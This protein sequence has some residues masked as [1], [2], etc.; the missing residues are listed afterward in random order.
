MM[1]IDSIKGNPMSERDITKYGA[2]IVRANVASGTTYWKIIDAYHLSGQQ[3]HGNH[4]VFADVLN[5]DG[6]RR[7]GAHC[8][9]YFAGRTAVLTIDKPA[10]EPGT[11]APMYRGNFYDIEGADLP[12]DKAIHFSSEWPDEE[13][14]NTNGHHSF[15]VIFQ[16]TI[17]G[18][19]TTGSIR[20]TVTNGAAMSIALTGANVNVSTQIGSDGG[21]GFD[22]V[23][24]GT[25]ML[26]VV[27]TSV[28]ATVSVQAGHQSSVTLV[29]PANPDVEALKRQIVA[30]QAQ[31]GQ[32]QQQLTQASTDRDR[33]K[34]ALTQIKQV[35]QDAGL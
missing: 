22:N 16:E 12:S 34:A 24:P 21:F 23:P 26:T 4:H 17:A 8:N 10:N 3:N 11:N 25:Y 33:F 1:P 6:T 31:V 2:A 9:L 29:V 13:E 20:G 19:V 7:M 32:L 27:G 5:A 18:D 35:I 30:L 28:T 14:G 15:M